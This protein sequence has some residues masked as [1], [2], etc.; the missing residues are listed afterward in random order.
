MPGEPSRRQRCALCRNEFR[1]LVIVSVARGS[2]EVSASLPGLETTEVSASKWRELGSR[3]SDAAASSADG[4]MVPDIRWLPSHVPPL[5]KA[6]EKPRLKTVRTVPREQNSQWPVKR[7]QEIA[8]STVPPFSCSDRICGLMVLPHTKAPL[9][10]FTAL[11][12]REARAVVTWK[13]PENV[14][15]PSGSVR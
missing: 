8:Y 4:S 7:Q 10:Q 9:T 14:G 6:R 15:G 3:T 1:L 13:S 5:N 11:D 12:R 2:R